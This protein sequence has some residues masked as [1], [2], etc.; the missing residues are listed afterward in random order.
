MNTK[1]LDDEFVLHSYA[2]RAIVFTHGVNATL[3]DENGCDYIDFTAGIGVSSVG[4]GNEKLLAAISD[5][6]A[7]IIHCSN[8]YLNSA[9]AQLAATLVRLCEIDGRCFF[10]NSGAEANEGAIKIARKYGE[11]RGRYKIIT[12]ANSF[13]GRTIAT[14]KATGQPKF[15]E[16][17][18]PFPDGFVYA[19]DLA[20]V[21]PLID[22]LTA[23][24]MIEPVQGEG[25]V[26]ALNK[27]ELT[28]LAK[29]LRDRDILLIADEIQCGVFR[30]GNFLAG[31]TLGI[32]PDVITLAKGLAGGV[33]IG[34]VITNRKDVFEYGDHGS[35]FGGNL[36]SS[37]GA[38][39]VLDVLEALQKSGKLAL[40]INH[41]STQCALIATDFPRL[42]TGETGLGL[43][44]ALIT[45]DE[46]TQK[47]IIDK[48]HDHGVLVLRAGNNQVRL[49][50]PLTITNAE[51][52]EGFSRLAAVCRAL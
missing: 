49:L 19:E 34:A 45:V 14:L 21:E 52:D 42:F 17:F 38:L 44:R 30:S 20:G 29:I 25:G 33:P 5:Q 37:C 40:T 16:H 47:A 23:A 26:T 50:P 12:L 31:K 28:K 36:L 11:K 6:T 1:E 39:A 35:T 22:D 2:R 3:Y 13:H 18:A 46:K 8:L 10:A 9:Q 48:A 7:K 43:M 27:N 51:I 24:V 15:H 32:S 41:F 4:H